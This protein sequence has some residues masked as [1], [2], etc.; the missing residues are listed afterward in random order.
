MPDTK[1]S[2][3]T[4]RV[5]NKSYAENLIHYHSILY[6]WGKELPMGKDVPVVLFCTVGFIDAMLGIL[7]PSFVS[8]MIITLSVIV[9]FS[10]VDEE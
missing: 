6:Y 7:Y 4:P 10:S 8:A 5:S 2:K 3:N 9:M 1:D